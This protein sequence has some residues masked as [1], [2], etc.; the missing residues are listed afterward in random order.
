MG[1]V[2]KM[3]FKLHKCTQTRLKY[4][5]YVMYFKTTR[6]NS[7]VKHGQNNEIYHKNLK[8][9]IPKNQ[10]NSYNV[11]IQDRGQCKNHNEIS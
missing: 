4:E 2:D 8:I 10:N 3:T 9:G 6:A 5:G 11:Q 1:K 7:G